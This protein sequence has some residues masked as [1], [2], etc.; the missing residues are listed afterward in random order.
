MIEETCTRLSER[1]PD[2]ARGQEEWTVDEEKH[3]RPWAEKRSR[4]LASERLSG[5]M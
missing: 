1:I 2:V 5:T 4:K 3:S